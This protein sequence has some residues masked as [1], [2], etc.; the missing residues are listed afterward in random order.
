MG[1][2]QVIIPCL[3]EEERLRE[4]LPFLLQ[5][6]GLQEGHI[7][8]VDGNSSDQSC[9]VAVEYSA[10]LIELA[11]ANRALQMNAGAAASD[12]DILYFL[13]ADCTPPRG[14]KS[15]IKKAVQNGAEAGAFR[16]R[17]KSNNPLLHVNNWCTRLPFL[18]C[19]GGDQSFFLTRDC[20]QQIGPYPEVAIMEEYFLWKKIF[21]KGI[22]YQLLPQSILANARKYEENS[23]WRV[24]W[25]NFR[26]F[27][28]FEKGKD[29]TL[30][31]EYYKD[32]LR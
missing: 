5:E 25:A 11:Q 26:A 18:W 29:S 31:A 13:H 3:N 19:R 32:R 28:M 30:I 6:P 8:V 7:I 16:L 4:L 9:E 2:F 20:W 1:S 10:Q 27:R 24:Q 15:F 17:M 12:A 14:F 22:P 23:Y 21:D